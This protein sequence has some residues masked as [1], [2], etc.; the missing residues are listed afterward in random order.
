RK[1]DSVSRGQGNG[2]RHPPRGTAPGPNRKEPAMRTTAVVTV[3]HVYAL[4]EADFS[5]LPVLAVDIDGEIVIFPQCT[6]VERGARILTDA[7]AL[8][9]YTD[10]ED[11]DDTLA[12]QF[13]AEI[14]EAHGLGEGSE[15]TDDTTGD[16]MRIIN[17]TPHT[18]TLVTAGGDEV[19]IPPQDSPV[20]IPA[21][22]TPAGEI[23][24]IP[25]VREQLGDADSVLPAP[26][27]GTVYVVARPVAERAGHRSDLVVP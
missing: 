26:Q 15:H 5:D 10:G 7:A 12:A 19:A 13:A 23:N 6:A 17:L 8:D 1:L 22:T 20:R 14:N 25:L 9:E 2:P 3:E 27:P 18:V 11:L 24:G 4:A 21:A 16:P